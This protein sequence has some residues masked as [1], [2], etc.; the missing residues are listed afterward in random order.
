MEEETFPTAAA[1]CP[2][3]MR[4]PIS[5]GG[6][7]VEGSGE[8]VPPSSSSSS[9]A[10]PPAHLLLPPPVGVPGFALT[11]NQLLTLAGLALP[12]HVLLLF[13]LNLFAICRRL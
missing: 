1:T 5:T 4:A 12:V 13:Q 8:V 2:D 7:V 6:D 3:A 11:K 10:I 9:V